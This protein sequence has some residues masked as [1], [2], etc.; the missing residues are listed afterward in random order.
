[1]DEVDVLGYTNYCPVGY[2]LHVDGTVSQKNV[3]QV[4][5]ELASQQIDGAIPHISRQVLEGREI[6]IVK[7]LEDGSGSACNIVAMAGRLGLKSAMIGLIGDDAE[8]AIV[9]HCFEVANVQTSL[10]VEKD[11]KR[12]PIE[13]FVIQ[14][15]VEKRRQFRPLDCV[16]ILGENDWQWIKSKLPSARVVCF[17]RAGKRATE[18]A[19]I[20]RQ[21]G[22]VV[23]YRIGVFPFRRNNQP[24]VFDLISR[25]RLL[26]MTDKVARRLT[27]VL[28]MS[29][30]RIEELGAALLSRYSSVEIVVIFQ[31]DEAIIIF[32]DQVIRSSLVYPHLQVQYPTGRHSAFHGALLVNLLNQGWDR[33]DAVDIQAALQFATLISALTSLHISVRL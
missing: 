33:G 25:T 12:T 32:E 26:T 5:E 3:W 1:M 21:N 27:G 20:V 7:Y 14:N 28:G 24:H 2:M 22:G 4:I 17:S 16:R 29:D 13:V 11:E 30:A 10:L 18:L 31:E 8:G 9:R 15:G 6:P 23:T 19:D